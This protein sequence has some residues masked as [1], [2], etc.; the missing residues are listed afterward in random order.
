MWLTHPYSSGL[1]Q[2]H[3]SKHIVVAVAVKWFWG[4]VK[5]TH[6]KPQQN[7][8]KQGWGL[9]RQFPPFRYFPIFSA[10]SKHTLAFK[11]HTDIW[12]VLPQLSCGGTCQIVWVK[13]FKIYF[14]KIKNFA[15]RDIN[16][17]SFRNP[18]PRTSVHNSWD[19]LCDELLGKLGREVE[20]NEQL[21]WLVLFL[22][23][24]HLPAFDLLQYVFDPPCNYNYAPIETVV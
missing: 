15:Y 20:C 4:L 14:C 10:L 19:V 16:E 8:T 13:W 18:H 3:W 17:R 24:V 5:L 9:L 11:Y 7:T 1:I 22:P 6:N 2:Q 12:Q 23:I 21:W